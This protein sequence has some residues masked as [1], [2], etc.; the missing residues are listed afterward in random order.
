MYNIYRKVYTNDFTVD[1]MLDKITQVILLTEGREVVGCAS[2]SL[3]RILWVGVDLDFAGQGYGKSLFK[4]IREAI[5]NSWITVGIDHPKVIATALKSGFKIARN[6]KS[7]ED[8]FQQGSKKKIV[9]YSSQI[10]SPIVDITD[11]NFSDRPLLGFSKLPDNDNPSNFHHGNEYT[12]VV[13]TAR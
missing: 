10:Y 1:T 4:T 3:N 9:A 12:Q 13:L 6:M 5:P 2:L 11:S 7:I 8:L